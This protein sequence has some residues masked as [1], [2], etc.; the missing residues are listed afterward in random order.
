[1]QVKKFEAP[2]LQEALDTIKRELGPEAIILQTKQNRRGFGLMS[3]GSVEVTAALSER[4][5]EKKASVEKRIPDNYRQKLAQAS[6]SK[7]ADVY[8]SYLEKKLEREQV[9]LSGKA[10]A[11]PKKITATRYVDI[12][13]EGGSA[14]PVRSEENVPEYSVPRQ[15]GSAIDQFAGSK[16]VSIQALRDEVEALKSLVEELRKDRKRAEYLDSD[17]PY[18]ATDA[19]ETAFDQLLQSGV[20]RRHAIQ[21]MRETSR[22]LGVEKRADHDQV[23]DQV[24]E[25][26]LKRIPVDPFFENGPPEG[27]GKVHAF[28]GPA[29]AGKT[30]LI[31]KLA[32]H[33]VRSRQ[34]KA[35]IIRVNLSIEEIQDPLVILAKA[36]H[37]PYRPV[38]SAEELQ[39]AIQ[40]M[41][42]CSRLFIDTPGIPV[43][44]LSSIR[45]LASILS[46]Q[47][48]LQV[49]LVSNANVRDRELREA[50]KSFSELKPAN[51]MFTRLDEALSLGGVYSLSQYLNLPVSVFSNGK[52][53]TENWE[54]ASAERLAAAILN[55]L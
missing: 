30:A 54:N 24:A 45:K 2:T 23:L 35:G 34:E 1:M 46:N 6:A 13:D 40:D 26:L 33:A 3:K 22:V 53:V 49:S 47:A 55:I 12:R 36:L 14:E 43:R 31:A 51:L 28:A 17:S 5:A 4:A 9:Q 21:I 52:K 42:Q 38:S 37:I 7:Q 27:A 10:S 41:S 39:V 25:Q 20:E 19:L 15:V 8:E 29:G 44:D 48:G 50:A 16:G 32:T 11:A 18:S